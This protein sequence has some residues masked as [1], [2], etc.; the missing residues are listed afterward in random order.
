MYT[1]RVRDF[2]NNLCL[3]NVT[4][5]QCLF[6]V[7]TCSLTVSFTWHPQK[8]MWWKEVGKQCTVCEGITEDLVREKCEK[9][10]SLSNVKS[11]KPIFLR[12]I[13]LLIENGRVILNTVQISIV[14]Y[15]VC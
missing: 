7:F 12:L 8:Y 10:V 11:H 6:L 5:N 15:P 3:I 1:V 13:R 4:Q 14:P 2:S 9:S